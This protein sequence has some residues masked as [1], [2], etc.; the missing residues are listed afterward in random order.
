MVYLRRTERSLY[1]FPFEITSRAELLRES[2]SVAVMAVLFALMVYLA[3]HAREIIESIYGLRRGIGFRAKTSLYLTAVVIVPLLA[4][5]IFVRAYLA[6]R[7]E[8]E[9]L[10]R[11]QTALNTAQRVVEDYVASSS[12]TAGPEQV[13]D[14]TILTWLA[15]VIGHDLHLYRD[16]EV[17]ASS[18]R[19]LFSAHI[20]SGRLPGSIYSR[21]VLVGSQLVR[22]ENETGS[23]K[24]VEIYSPISLGARGQQYTLALPFILQA[25]QIEKQVN[26][27]AT[28]I[29]LLLVVIGLAALI[30]AY[31]AARGVTR[32]VQGLVAGARSVA[33]GHFDVKLAVPSDPDLRLLVTTFREMA[34]SIRKQQ[35]DLRHE[36]DR[37]QTL[38]ENI[39][40]AVVVLDG[41]S[42]IMA[43]NVASR[44][45]FTFAEY[46]H[47]PFTTE[48]TDVNAFVSENRRRQAAKEIELTIDDTLRTFRVSIVPLP[49]GNEEMLIAEDV[50][51]ILRSN[52]LEAWSEMARQVAHEIK[53][54][55]TPIQL[56]AEHLRAVSAR[57]DQSLPRVVETA[58]DNI[59][60]QVETLRETS[61]EFSDYAS[62]R[63]AKLEPLQLRKFL[64]EIIAAYADSS[65]RGI[66]LRSTLAE[67]LPETMRADARLLR[68]A[69]VNLIENA[70]QAT[71]AGGVVELK[72]GLD[73][74]ALVMEL[75][76]SGPGVEHDLLP[77]IFDPYF[78]TK[79]TG[80]GLGLAIARKAIEEHGGTIGAEN[81]ASGGLMVTIRI[82]L[83]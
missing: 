64:S 12:T 39:N 4:F 70:L 55:L 47:R 49:E 54:P 18:R 77:K 69:I 62:L 72:V 53:N 50:T 65:E 41:S 44:K 6:D 66:E 51:E 34:Q 56:T 17:L 80:T 82:P 9:Y 13:L 71:P 15:R 27:L 73:G 2:G 35:D 61:K 23:A 1:G 58:V 40:A 52:R 24:F 63:Q 11:G 28:T 26:D 31:R 67:D 68:G 33:S 45:L 74:R 78:S 36:R 7:L 38:L 32:P 79:S 3:I 59:L 8:A 83:K 48:F 75:T 76:D 57:G 19:D 10:E 29:Y 30:V 14:D 46:D 20:E 43:T 60:R 5:V 37:L 42:R 16:D 22:A 25:R 81:K 21:V